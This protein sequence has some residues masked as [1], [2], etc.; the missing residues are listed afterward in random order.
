MKSLTRSLL[1]ALALTTGAWV[2]VQAQTF[3]QSVAAYERKDYK[4]AFTGFKRLAEQGDAAKP[5]AR[6]WKPPITAPHAAARY[7]APPAAA[8]FKQRHPLEYR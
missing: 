4:T 7:W 8:P 3:E 5:A 2:P 6:N 1:L